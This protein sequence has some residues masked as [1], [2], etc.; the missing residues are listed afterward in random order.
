MKHWGNLVFVFVIILTKTNVGTDRL[1][2]LKN[3]KF[4][5]IHGISRYTV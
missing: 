1:P 2:T 5:Y 4:V 3:I